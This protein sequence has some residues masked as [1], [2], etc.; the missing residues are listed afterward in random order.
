[1]SKKNIF[2]RS[3]WGQAADRRGGNA[4][5]E[6]YQLPSTKAI[7]YRSE[8]DYMS[9]CVLDYPNI[10]TGGQLFGFWTST[11]TPVVTYVI[12][13]G[14][15]AVHNSTSFIQDQEYLQTLGRALHKRYR[16]QHIGEWHS[17]HRLGLTYPSGGDVNT[18]QY[19]VGKPGF[20]RLLLCI[21]T[22]DGNRTTV[23][24]Y[25]FHENMPG[26][27]ERAAWDVIDIESPYRRLADTELDRLLLHPMT[28]YPSHG[29]IY[30]VQQVS[31][32]DSSTSTHWL[33]ESV[34]NVE[35][36]KAMVAIVQRVYPHAQV[37]AEMLSS[38]EPT[39]VVPECGLSV[40]LPH[41]FPAQSPELMRTS[42]GD[43]YGPPTA[44]PEARSVGWALSEEPLIDTFRNWF[45][46][47]Q[48]PPPRAEEPHIPAPLVTPPPFVPKDEP[49]VGTTPDPT[50]PPIPEIEA[51]TDD[52][53]INNQPNNTSNQ[54][55]LWTNNEE[56]LKSR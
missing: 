30:T 22:L 3:Y 23:N 11:G 35:T 50:P 25:N 34:E 37:K 13:P 46:A 32:P 17:H 53:I 18:M 15:D 10:E 51:T 43:G 21:A 5:A 1:M 33:T 38:G 41:G 14:Y 39:I 56:D 36:M 40:K 45:L 28:Q 55:P 27:Y 12:G 48:V 6:D 20:P 4:T 44:A 42:L 26:D 31:R 49:P 8:L 19:G 52:E 2:K 24:A 7:I 16:L 54:Q 47:S 9:R 29:P